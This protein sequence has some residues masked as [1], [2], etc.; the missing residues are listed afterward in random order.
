MSRD[1]HTGPVRPR[2]IER[3]FEPLFVVP[4]KGR[5]ILPSIETMEEAMKSMALTAVAIGLLS[6]TAFSMP[7]LNQASSM[8]RPP[9]AHWPKTSGSSAKKAD[10]AIASG[11]GA[12][13][14]AGSMAM[15]HF[16]A[17]TMVRATTV[18]LDA[19]IAGPFLAPG[20]TETE[21]LSR[22]FERPFGPAFR[23]TE[24]SF[25]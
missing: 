13:R 21:V 9:L 1:G 10:C 2:L 18:P 12:P 24:D 8:A 4:G 19:V 20:S 15:A 22:S 16:T 3:G 25:Q 7:L 14:R 17:L 5:G 23:W 11:A 6:T